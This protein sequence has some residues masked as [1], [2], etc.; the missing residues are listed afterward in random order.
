MNQN[1]ND[2]ARNEET[3]PEERLRGRPIRWGVIAND[4]NDNLT[5]QVEITSYAG[6]AVVF[7]GNTQDEDRGNGSAWDITQDALNAMGWNG[8]LENMQLDTKRTVNLGI[9]KEDYKG[10]IR[11]RVRI[12]ASALDTKAASPDAVRRLAARLGLDRDR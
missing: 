2:A 7:Y 12:W 4:K 1:Q 8:S 5:I 11:D 6:R 3:A 9:T 10:K